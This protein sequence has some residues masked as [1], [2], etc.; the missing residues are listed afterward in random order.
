MA[1][2]NMTV[3]IEGLDELRDLLDRLEDVIER[4]KSL[5]PVMG[6]VH[7]HAPSDVREAA[8]TALRNINAAPSP[9][10]SDPTK[11]ATGGFTG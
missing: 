9:D 8:K 11:Y 10:R 4:T 5:R 2:A 1:T 7:I 3:K 6:D